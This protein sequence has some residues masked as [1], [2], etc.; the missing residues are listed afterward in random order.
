MMIMQVGQLNWWLRNIF[1]D[2]SDGHEAV[3]TP[4]IFWAMGDGHQNYVMDLGRDIPLHWLVCDRIP[5]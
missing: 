2:D 5:W 4:S 3:S 1:F